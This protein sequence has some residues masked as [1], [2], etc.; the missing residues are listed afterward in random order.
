[1]I[2]GKIA[3][4]LA[5]ADHWQLHRDITALEEGGADFLHADV[6][7][8]IFVQNFSL[9]T[10][11]LKSIKDRVKIPIEVHLQ[12]AYPERFVDKFGE[13]GVGRY[14]FHYEACDRLHQMAIAIG[15]SGM[16]MGVAINPCTPLTV[17]ETVLPKLAMVTLM[18]VEPG[19]AGQE[20]IEG[21][22]PKIRELRKICNQLGL[23]MDIAVDGN[24][25][26]ETIPITAAA[27]ANVFIL[28]TSSIFTRQGELS[29]LTKKFKLIAEQAV[30]QSMDH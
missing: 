5:C 21:V 13:L 17:L 29:E 24:V 19:F 6:M 12:T 28:G 2:K 23:E 7:D 11:L 14:T 26:A 30:D 27:G 4:S 25:N 3:P 16:E 9:G 10:D 15:N 20:F 18:T 1:M 22:V 8:G